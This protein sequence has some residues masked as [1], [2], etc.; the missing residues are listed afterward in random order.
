MCAW[1]WYYPFFL[2]KFLSVKSIS[3]STQKHLTELH[4]FCPYSSF[5]V[6]LLW[7]Y[8]ILHLFLKSI[9]HLLLHRPSVSP[10]TGEERRRREGEKERRREEEKKRRREGERERERVTRVNGTHGEGNTLWDGGQCV[11]FTEHWLSSSTTTGVFLWICLSVA[12][13][14]PHWG[15]ERDVADALHGIEKTDSEVQKAL[16]QLVDA[17]GMKGRVKGREETSIASFSFLWENLFDN[18]NICFFILCLMRHITI[19]NTSQSI[20]R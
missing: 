16:V 1:Y 20:R 7:R 4:H 8:V 10:Y 15:G 11:S 19:H 17:K 12:T 6:H 9:H 3:Y 18:K 14:R 13:H 2:N 5:I